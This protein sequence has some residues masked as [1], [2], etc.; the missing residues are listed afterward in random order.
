M[1]EGTSLKKWDYSIFFFFC[2][3][4][5]FRSFYQITIEEFVRVLST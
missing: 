1:I 4:F 3:D 5:S 2:L